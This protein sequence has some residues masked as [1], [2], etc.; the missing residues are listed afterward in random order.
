MSASREFLANTITRP[1]EGL[2][3]EPYQYISLDKAMGRPCTRDLS[4]D[5]WDILS[6][7]LLKAFAKEF[8]RRSVAKVFARSFAGNP[9]LLE[10]LQKAF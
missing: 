3:E 9:T 10:G 2:S 1:S 5:S 8:R 6:E 4:Q 7:G